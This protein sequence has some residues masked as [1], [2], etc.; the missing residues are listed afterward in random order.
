MIEGA[1]VPLIILGDP[2]YPLLKWLIKAYTGSNSSPEKS[3][4][5]C[6]HSSV[7]IMVEI[8]FGRLKGARWRIIGKKIEANVSFA[9]TIVAACCILHNICENG[10]CPIGEIAINSQG[11]EQPQTRPSTHEMA[12]GIAVRDALLKY[13]TDNLPRRE[14]LRLSY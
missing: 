2:A 5:N 9:P 8:A 3:S 12:E 13:V 7:R 10:N 4:F 6:Y 14:A 11:I 1:S